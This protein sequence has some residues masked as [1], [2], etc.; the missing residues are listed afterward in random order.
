MVGG[1]PRI[2]AWETTAAR[3]LSK[4]LTKSADPPLLGR[5]LIVNPGAE[6]NAG[7]KG[8]AADMQIIGWRDS[9]SMTVVQYGAPSG[10]PTINGPGPPSKTRGENFFGGGQSAG[11]RISQRIDVSRLNEKIDAGQVRYELSAYLGGYIGQNDHTWLVASF[12]DAS[13]RPVRNEPV[14]VGPVTNKDRGNLTG[15]LLRE[16]SGAVPVGTRMIEITLHAVRDPAA[17]GGADGYAD[18]LSLVLRD[19]ESKV[20]HDDP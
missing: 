10:F 9:G 3:N 8:D 15:L 19:E 5:N 6:M 1:E 20:M 12:L 13:G 7:N 2:V 18:N 14:Q 11:S 17:G 4:K 16:T